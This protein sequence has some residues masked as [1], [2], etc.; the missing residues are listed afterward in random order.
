MFSIQFK[1]QTLLFD[2]KMGPYYVVPH[3]VRVNLRVMVMKVYSHDWSLTIKMFSVI[4]RT[5]AG[6]VL[7]LGRDEVS[8]GQYIL[9]P[10]IYE[11]IKCIMNNVTF[12]ICFFAF[13]VCRYHIRKGM[14]YLSVLTP[15]QRYSQHIPQPQLT[16]LYAQLGIGR[17]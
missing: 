4:S 6:R 9:Q 15:L 3:R 5:Q 8:I 1:C 2:Q 10:L 12:P 16:W 11:F 14:Q 13:F 7:N 17:V